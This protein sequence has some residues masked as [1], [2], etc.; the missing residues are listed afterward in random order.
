MPIV[1]SAD[2][3]ALDR[4][5]GLRTLQRLVDRDNGSD[6]VTVLVNEF[7]RDETVPE[8]THETEE[9]LVVVAGA[10]VAT[11]ADQQSAVERGDAVIVPPGT[12]HAIHGSGGPCTVV[13]VLGS[14]D[15]PVPTPGVTAARTAGTGR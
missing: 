15:A 11:V 12:P 9:V 14:P 13:A 8:H 7:R 4:G 3:P 10:C 5:P 6:A 1:R 2:R